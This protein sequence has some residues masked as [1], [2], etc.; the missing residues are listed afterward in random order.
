MGE[1]RRVAG[2]DGRRVKEEGMRDGRGSGEKEGITERR[3]II[4]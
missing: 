4:N 2:K 3:K 1:R